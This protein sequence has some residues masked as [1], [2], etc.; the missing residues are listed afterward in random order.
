MISLCNKIICWEQWFYDS[1]RQPLDLMVFQWFPMVAN[2]WYW[3]DPSLWSNWKT[4]C[5]LQNWFSIYFSKQNSWVRLVVV[6]TFQVP[7]SILNKG[8]CDNCIY[9][10]WR[11]KSICQMMTFQVPFSV[12]N[13]GA[14]ISALTGQ[15]EVQL[16]W[17]MKIKSYLSSCS[18]WTRYTSSFRTSSRSSGRRRGTRWCRSCRW[19]WRCRAGC[20]CTTPR[21]SPPH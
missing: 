11:D 19:T 12:L 17:E 14:H 1:F 21:G 2:R 6:I 4:L 20:R 15:L 16:K 10:N 3:N 8:E 5:I 7:L 18:H 9:K 13:I